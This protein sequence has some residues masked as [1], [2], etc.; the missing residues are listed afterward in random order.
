MLSMPEN[1]LVEEFT[2]EKD[3]KLRQQFVRYEKFKM[4]YV[5]AQQRALEFRAYWE[6][7]HKDDRDLW[8]DKVPLLVPSSSLLF[9]IIRVAADFAN[10][11]DKMSRAGY[12][13][14]FGDHEVPEE[15]KIK[16]DA[17]Y[18]QV[19]SGDYEDESD[20]GWFETA[21]ARPMWIDTPVRLWLLNFLNTTLMLSDG[22]TALRCADEWKL[23]AG[24]TKIEAQREFI[25]TTNKILTR[26]G[27]NP[28]DGWV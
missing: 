3:E 5:E 6:R 18:M 16:L 13:G 20:S 12:K 10:A 23:L 24:K 28:P 1:D 22:N 4:E 27:W 17:L 15:D 26:Y 25:H 9:Q 8:R 2:E 19:T 21:L 11:V 14:E 7:R